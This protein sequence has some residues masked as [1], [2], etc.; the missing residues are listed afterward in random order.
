MQK[1]NQT[2]GF[3]ARRYVKKEIRKK[4]KALK[5]KRRE[6]NFLGVDECFLFCQNFANF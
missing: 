2:K 3:R 6:N 1:K 4:G 5:N